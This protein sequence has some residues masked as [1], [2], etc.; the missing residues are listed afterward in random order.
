[1]SENSETR[2]SEEDGSLA[3]P[4]IWGVGAGLFV[5]VLTRGVLAGGIVVVLALMVFGAVV[6]SSRPRQPTRREKKARERAPILRRGP[7]KPPSAMTK[8]AMQREAPVD[9]AAPGRPADWLRQ[10]QQV[11]LGRDAPSEAEGRVAIENH[12]KPDDEFPTKD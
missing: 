11:A 1:V 3:I 2:K 9:R 4:V 5:A 8:A 7:P 10:A 12:A 6:L